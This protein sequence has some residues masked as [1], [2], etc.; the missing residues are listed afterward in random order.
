MHGYSTTGYIAT[1]FRYYVTMLTRLG[2]S[3]FKSWERIE[4]MRLAPLTG[5]FGTNSSGKSAILQLLLLLKQTKD[6][7]DRTQVLHFGDANS[8][9]NF[10]TFKDLIHQHE[11]SKKLSWAVKWSRDEP[12]VISDPQQRRHT[13]LFR[14]QDF[15][16]T[17][18]I[19]L[20][21]KRQLLAERIAYTFGEH[22][23]VLGRKSD[24]DPAYRLTVS[25]EDFKFVRY[26]GRAWD[27]PGPVK[28]YAFPDQVLTYYQNSGFLAGLVLAFEQQMDALFYLGPLRESPKA[29]Y[30]W[31]GARPVDVGK[32]GERAIDALL[33]ARD[34]GEVISR[35]QGRRRVGLDEYVALWLK[36]LNLISSFRVEKFTEES[37]LYR[38][39]VKINKD[40][41]ESLITEVGFVV[42][43]VLP[44]LV[45]LYYVPEGSTVLLEQPE[46]HLH[47]S[48]QSGLA[49]VL[50]DAIRVRGIQVIVE[51]HSEHLLRRLQRRI[52]EEDFDGED[53]ALYF[54]ELNGVASSLT[55]LRLDLFGNIVNWPQS[56]F[57]DD[58][59]EIAAIQEAVI[60][61]KTAAAECRPMSSIPT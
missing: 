60:K 34:S 7:T 32:K 10:G 11:R 12:L 25:P 61:R 42:S 27:L 8:L 33:A 28:S 15:A 22:T 47:P 21:R 59:A 52:A 35:G 18:S 29:E 54:C 26:Q 16:L 48:V 5:L 38:V 30:L 58:F 3:N 24:D 40:S 9:T 1:I 50:I 49:D 39:K 20:G 2:I 31:S 43:Q 13:E 51:S 57:G 56:F 23:F 41:S 36:R 44:V 55:P 6:S 46:I 37:N 14:G 17:S 45:L 53:A 19:G 4:D